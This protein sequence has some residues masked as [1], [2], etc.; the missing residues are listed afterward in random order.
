[1]AAEMTIPCC[2]NYNDKTGGNFYDSF[3]FSHLEKADADRW[4]RK[5]VEGNGELRENIEVV[6]EDLSHQLSWYSATSYALPH[7]AALCS[8]L[9]KEDKVYLIAQMRARRPCAGRLC[10]C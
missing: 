10:P 2:L 8:R 7:L 6:A 4:L 3:G 5:L 9:S 1:M